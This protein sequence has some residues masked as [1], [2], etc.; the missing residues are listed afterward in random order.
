M[1]SPEE[2]LG[3]SLFDIVKT[4]KCRMVTWIHRY[5]DLEVIFVKVE[6]DVGSANELSKWQHIQWIE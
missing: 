4:E 2:I 1:L 6:M 3:K 5:V